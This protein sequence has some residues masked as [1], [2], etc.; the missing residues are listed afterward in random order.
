MMDRDSHGHTAKGEKNGMSKLS[1]IQR[2]EIRQRHDSGETYREISGHYPVS[3]VQVY[4]ICR[5]VKG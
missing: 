5:D 4:R 2:G 3:H 1:D